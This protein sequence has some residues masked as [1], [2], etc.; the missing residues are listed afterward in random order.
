MIEKQVDV[1]TPDGVADCDLFYPGENGQW[2][3]IIMYTDI[4]GRRPVF[5]EM[6][7]RLAAEGFVVL[8]PNPFYR[9]SRAPV[10]R[11]FKFG[12]EATT[13][14]MGEVRKFVTPAGIDSDAH[15]YIAFLGGLKQV[16]GKM[17]S[18]GYCMGGGMAIRTAAAE[19]QKIAAAASFHGGNLATDAP[20]S[21]HLLASKIKARLYFGFAIEDRSTP[22][23]AVE[24]LKAA[25]DAVGVNYEGETY[26][27]ARH[28]WCVKDHNV[29]DEH[30]AEHAWHHLVELFKETLE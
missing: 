10:Y 2:P 1:K 14:R 26:P 12:T 21:P 18:V 13:A 16:T 7:K 5:V 22:P 29:Y 9:L 30:Q 28:G 4:G 6:G 17:G 20:D 11:D 19:P 3:A 25:L 15:A 24:K 27:G 23:E 8:V